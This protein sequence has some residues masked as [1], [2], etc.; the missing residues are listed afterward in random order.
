MKDKYYGLQILRALAAWIVVLHHVVQTFYTFE[1]D[2]KIWHFFGRY[3][4]IGVDA[5]FVLSGFI[6]YYS[7]NRSTK[8]GVKFFFD[9]LLRIFPAYWAATLLLLLSHEL[10]PS[11]S[12]N[13]QYTG[14]SLL[15]SLLLIPSENPS[16]HG[17][18]PF[19][20]VGWTLVY[21]MFFYTVLSAAL[22]LDRKRAI[23]LALI[24][25]TLLPLVLE[26]L[27]Y[28][29]LG[30]S[31]FFL[32]E[33]NIGLVIAFGFERFVAHFKPSW[34]LAMLVAGLAFQV[35]V[36]YVGGWNHP[37]K[38][39][40]ASTCVVMFL[41]AEPFF[42]IQSAGIRLLVHLGNLSYST[43]LLHPVLLGWFKLTYK[44]AA[45]PY[46]EA[47][48]FT[49]FVVLLYLL[50]YW[51]YQLIEVSPHINTFKKYVVRKLSA[52]QPVPTL[53]SK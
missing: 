12:Y 7:L 35:A 23:G 29:P 51:S 40:V 24:T 41:L 1:V 33:F 17:T 3:G 22:L 9:R 20:Y 45:S 50:S 8:T 5:F 27:D 38:L 6:M 2:N 48:L 34:K 31:N 14:E 30:S 10:F 15:Q 53:A 42:K 37:T 11:G 43:Y 39:L 4:T 25:L 44:S 47:V 36:L 13:T 19:L 46:V 28:M 16:G 32:Y 49:S 18:Y 21:E 26:L 52:P